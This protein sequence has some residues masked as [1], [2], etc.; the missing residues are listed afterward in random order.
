MKKLL[1]GILLVPVFAFSD[2]T[3]IVVDDENLNSYREEEMADLTHI[4]QQVS[5][6]QFDMAKNEI[7]KQ[8]A[9][10]F[11]SQMYIDLT[12]I[13]IAIKMKDKKM[14]KEYMRQL[15]KEYD[16]YFSCID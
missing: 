8:K 12:Q 4:W 1:L 5:T 6:Q 11:N 14:I 10:N 16:G 13:Y 2:S 9:F 15:E 3:P 7:K